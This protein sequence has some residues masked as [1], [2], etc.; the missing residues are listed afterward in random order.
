MKY[1][2]KIILKPLFIGTNV[3]TCVLAIIV[4]I[5][6]FSWAIIDMTC[7]NFNIAHPY[8]T[9]K[10]ICDLLTLSHLLWNLLS[11]AP[12]VQVIGFPHYQ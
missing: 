1:F 9:V 6:I 5:M 8:P 4:T 7:R 11:G 3:H 12:A 10:L 2:T